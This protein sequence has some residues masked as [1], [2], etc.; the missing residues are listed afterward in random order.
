MGLNEKKKPGMDASGRDQINS[1]EPT[2]E[3]RWP[4]IPANSEIPTE[5]KVPADLAPKGDGTPVGESQQ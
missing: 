3:Q 2:Y 5:Y 4:H 1:S